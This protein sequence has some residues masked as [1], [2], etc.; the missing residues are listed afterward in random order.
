MSIGD[1]LLNKTPK[2]NLEIKYTP[3]ELTQGVRTVLK[4]G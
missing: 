2:N 1:I 3:K 4:T